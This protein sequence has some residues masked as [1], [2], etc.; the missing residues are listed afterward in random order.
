LLTHLQALSP[1]EWQAAK[2][3]LEELEEVAL[4]RRS[5]FYHRAI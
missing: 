4:E 3:V 1:H 2:Q 5:E